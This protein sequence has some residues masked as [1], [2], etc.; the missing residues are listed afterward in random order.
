M[1]PPTNTLVIGDL[2]DGAI[3]ITDPQVPDTGE[4]GPFVCVTLVIRD[5]AAPE[6]PLTWPL[7]WRLSSYGCSS[8][9]DGG[10]VQLDPWNEGYYG[11]EVP[12]YDPPPVSGRLSLDTTVRITDDWVAVARDAGAELEPGDVVEL[13]VSAQSGPSFHPSS[14]SAGRSFTLT[15]PSPTPPGAPAP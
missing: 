10:D 15:V 1:P 2:V 7:S 5:P 4:P 14:N 13:A 6:V 11:T 9:Q 12:G 8:S 3:R